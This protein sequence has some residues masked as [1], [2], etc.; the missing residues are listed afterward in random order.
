MF[1]LRFGERQAGFVS[2]APTRFVP[3]RAIK[4]LDDTPR[5]LGGKAADFKG[6]SSVQWDLQQ[7]SA[8]LRGTIFCPKRVVFSAQQNKRLDCCPHKRECVE[9]ANFGDCNVRKLLP[10][11]CFFSP[12]LLCGSRK[13]H[14]LSSCHKQQTSDRPQDGSQRVPREFLLHWLPCFTT[15][16]RSNLNGTFVRNIFLSKQVKSVSGSHLNCSPQYICN[17]WNLSPHLQR[18]SINCLNNRL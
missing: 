11:R 18:T 10:A 16:K 17:R 5:H 13:L 14:M 7:T 3:N 8:A 6:L 2:G 9:G 15:A 4:A 12:S 1:E